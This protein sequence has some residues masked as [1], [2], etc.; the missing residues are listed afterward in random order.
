MRMGEWGDDCRGLFR[1]SG[2][3]E[4]HTLSR[5]LTNTRYESPWFGHARIND[6]HELIAQG[7]VTETDYE[8][9]LREVYARAESNRY[10]YSLTCYV[11]VG[12][13][14]AL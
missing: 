10:F 8:R 13:S 1:H 5:L 14:I 6:F 2:R 7:L 12:R 3:F 4:G 9:L 11:F